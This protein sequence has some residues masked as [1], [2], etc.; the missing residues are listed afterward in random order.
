MTV[1]E[2]TSL[3][4]QISPPQ[5]A[6]DARSQ[7]LSSVAHDI[8]TPLSTIVALAELMERR[9][10]ENLLPSQAEYLRIMRI[11]GLRLSA[12]IDDLLDIHRC[13]QDKLQLST[14]LFAPADVIVD[15]IDGLRPLL[16]RRRQLVDM[17][18]E[19]DG[20]ILN[21]DRNRLGQIMGNLLGNASKYSPDSSTIRVTARVVG[22]QL[23]VSIRDNGSGIDD[24]TRKRAFERYY[25]GSTH[26]PSIPG[27]GLGLA[28]SKSLVELHGGGIDII[29]HPSEGTEVVICLPGAE[30]QDLRELDSRAAV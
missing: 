13:E 11:N 5:C 3:E 17:E 15:S 14:T 25:R 6:I 16:E 1:H 30:R 9:G 18:I 7:F 24:E 8:R 20:V 22:D 27:S 12:L 2:V 29:S 21:A 28:I 4:N 10:V 23:Y 26:A 19:L